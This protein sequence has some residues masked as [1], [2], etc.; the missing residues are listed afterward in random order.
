MLTIIGGLDIETTGL[1][2]SDGHRIIEIAL[3]PFVLETQQRLTPLLWR[4][5]PERSIDPAAQAVHKISFEDVMLCPK[6]GD[7]APRFAL[8]L[9]KMNAV[10]A[11]NGESFDI[12]F[13]NGEFMRIG[14][15]APSNYALVDTCV[16]GRWATPMGKI[17]NLRELC[18]AT[19]VDY[20]P[21]LAH[22]ADYD[23]DCMMKAFFVGY[24]KGF[25]KIPAQA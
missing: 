13:I 7:V 17:P 8:A 1:S 12:P 20:N 14:Q 4:I 6:W 10:V 5:N 21:E 18:F 16:Q 19:G 23:V 9:S 22:R 15:P 2:Q 24:E 25:F 3:H 11:H